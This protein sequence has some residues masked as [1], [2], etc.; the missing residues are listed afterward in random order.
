M[1]NGSVQKHHRDDGVFELRAGPLDAV[2]QDL[3]VIE[4]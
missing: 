2:A 3:D 1:V 4:R